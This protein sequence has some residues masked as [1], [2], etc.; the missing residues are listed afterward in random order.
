MSAPPSRPQIRVRPNMRPSPQ[1]LQHMQQVQMAQM[2]Q[3]FTPQQIQQMQMQGQIPQMMSAPRPRPVQ[4]MMRPPTKPPPPVIYR[5]VSEL[6]SK[7]PVELMKEARLAQCRYSQAPV[8]KLI[9]ECL[10]SLVPPKEQALP[11]T[12]GASFMRSKPQKP[13]APVETA[14]DGSK[15]PVTATRRLEQIQSNIL[16]DDIKMQDDSLGFVVTGIQNMADEIGLSFL[17]MLHM[18][19]GEPV[20]LCLD[21]DISDVT[22]L[23]ATY[24]N[25]MATRLIEA[26]LPPGA[27][28]LLPDHLFRVLQARSRI[29]PDT[30]VKDDEVESDDDCDPPEEEQVQ[31]TEFQ[32]N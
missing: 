27:Q 9:A 12:S 7:S 20:Q 24:M 2:A 11:S 23:V 21:P 6:I 5:P 3:Q 15:R 25:I 14:D 31:D 29:P 4:M 18:V 19:P 17:D 16:R 26:A 13:Q 22:I 32:E 1:Q 30:D 8:V 28:C 10:H